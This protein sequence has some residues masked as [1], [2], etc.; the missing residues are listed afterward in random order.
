MFSVCRLDILGS[1]GGCIWQILLYCLRTHASLS[2]SAGWT[3]LEVWVAAYDRFFCTVL[4]HSHLLF[5]VCRLDTLGSMG[6]CLWQI[7]LYCLRTFT[8]LVLCLQAGHTGQHAGIR[9]A[10]WWT[11]ATDVVWPRV[12][13]QRLQQCATQ[14]LINKPVLLSSVFELFRPFDR[15]FCLGRG[16]WKY[17]HQKLPGQTRLGCGLENILDSIYQS[18]MDEG[19]GGV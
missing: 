8:P 7:L 18:N 19:Y 9:R 17:G 1:M 11:G 4:E 14:Q 2:L 10:G 12:L 15:F 16:D 6:S 5:S 3:H 13:L